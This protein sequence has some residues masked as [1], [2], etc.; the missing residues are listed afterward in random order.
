MPLAPSMCPPVMCAPCARPS[1]L[2]V[3]TGGFFALQLPAWIAWL[4]WLSYIYY[5]LQVGGGGG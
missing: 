2:Q 3:L 4:K 5:A 1:P